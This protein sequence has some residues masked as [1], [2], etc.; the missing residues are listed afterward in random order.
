[1]DSRTS[2][3]VTTTTPSTSATTTIIHSSVGLGSKRVSIDD[4]KKYLGHG[5]ALGQERNPGSYRDVEANTDMGAAPQQTSSLNLTAPI[6][7]DGGK[8]A[9]LTILGWY[10]PQSSVDSIS[11]FW[12]A[13][14][15]E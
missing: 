3:D 10:V 9:W 13:P 11:A 6:P 4:S 2:Q 5:Q 14:S 15:T 1:M 7:L 8:T 12:I